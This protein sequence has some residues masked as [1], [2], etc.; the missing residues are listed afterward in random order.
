MVRAAATADD[1]RSRILHAA[2]EE[3]YRNGFQAGSLNHIA[4][5]VGATKGALFHYF[6]SKQDLGYAVVDEMIQPASKRRWLDPLD[7]ES[8]PVDAIKNALRRNIAEDVEAG[9]PLECGCP[10]N[11]L[12]QEMSPLDEGFRQRIEQGYRAWRDALAAALERGQQQGRVRADVS[13]EGAAALI[14]AGQMGIWGTAKNSQ[15]Q[16]LMRRASEA[17]CAYLESLRPSRKSGDVSEGGDAAE[18]GLTE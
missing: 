18:R 3:F 1:M 15:D 7:Q 6:K 12:A 5:S 10:L 9:A 17:L 8:D 2:F 13:P 11:N 4:A 14:V 16:E